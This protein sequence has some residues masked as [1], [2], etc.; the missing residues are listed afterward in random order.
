MNKTIK[1]AFAA[2]GVFA[3]VEVAQAVP[4][5]GT[6]GIDGVVSLNTADANTATEATGWTSPV[7][8]G[9]SGTFTPIPLY[10]AVDFT[11]STWYFDSSGGADDTLI[12]PFWKVDGFQ[13]NFVSSTITSQHG[14][15]LHLNLFGTVS[16]AG[17]DTTAMFGAISLSNDGGGLGGANSST[18]YVFSSSF[19][20]TPSVPD[21]GMTVLLLGSALAGIGFMKR[22]SVV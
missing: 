1:L 6:I 18:E 13:F 4:I 9:S 20:A 8:Y 22:K 17:Y 3:A 7:N 19:S 2:V 16:A 11:S 12:P 15:V 14:G 21:G 5:S 10:N